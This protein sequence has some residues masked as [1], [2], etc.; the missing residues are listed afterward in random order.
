MTIGILAY[1]SLVGDPGDELQP[2]VVRRIDVKTPFAIEFARS[3]G[4]RCGGP[5]L[6]RVTAGGAAV[7]ASVLVL[8][9]TVDEELARDLLYRRETRRVGVSYRDAQTDWISTI[10]LAGLS[11]CVY[12]DL[13]PNIDPLTVARLA[14]FAITSAARAAGA[15]KKDGIS[16]LEEQKRRGLETPLMPGYEAEVLSQTGGR[17][18]AD[19]WTRVREGRRRS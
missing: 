6:V 17:D 7:D 8:K 15:D 1:G 2:Y 3:S 4:T 14:Q 19:A 18:L 13:K 5:T 16:Y 10:S 11:A 12:T 9:D